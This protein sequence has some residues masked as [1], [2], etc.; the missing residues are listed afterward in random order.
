[1][2]GQ[3]IYGIY[4]ISNGVDIPINSDV[5][6]PSDS[7]IQTKRQITSNTEE[8]QTEEFANTFFDD[9]K[10][11]IERSVI[12]SPDIGAIKK[13]KLGTKRKDSIDGYKYKNII[14][15]NIPE[16]KEYQSDS[17]ETIDLD[18][19]KNIAHLKNLNDIQ[20]LQLKNSNRF[21]QIMEMYFS[22]YM[23]MRN[24]FFNSFPDSINN[25]IKSTSVSQYNNTN[26]D[27]N[28]PNNIGNTSSGNNGNIN[29]INDTI[30]APKINSDTTES[31]TQKLVNSLKLHNNI[32]ENGFINNTHS[33][34]I[35][36][37]DTTTSRTTTKLNLNQGFYKLHHN[38]NNN[39]NSN[40]NKL[41]FLGMYN[42]QLKNQVISPS[43]STRTETTGSNTILTEIPTTLA[44]T[45][46]N[47]N[48]HQ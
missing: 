14:N 11:E 28:N 45:S 22:N 25:S 9:L 13:V 4:P 42:G 35:T 29:D 47:T 46:S 19:I 17:D 24:A 18:D 15:K 23:E 7:A 39:D 16:N 36:P 6:K 2:D 31:K 12:K 48:N 38:P 10:Q 26:N 8:S 3:A 20:I 41:K 34:I 1:M 37:T 43:E 32:L 30:P 40:I 5:L 44:E 21:N 33:Q 27:N